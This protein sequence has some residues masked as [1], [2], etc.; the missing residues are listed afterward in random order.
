MNINKK[1]CGEILIIGEHNT[2]KSTLMNKLIEKKVSITS[3]KKNTTQKNILGIQTT[4]NYQFIYIDTPGF[5][6]NND[7]KKFLIKLNIEEKIKKKLK[8]IILVLDKIFWSNNIKIITNFFKKKK[9]NLIIALNK[10]DKIKKKEILLPFMKII[11]E[12]SYFKEIIPVSAKTGEN[13]HILK[14]EI[15]K[16]LPQKEHNF[17]KNTHENSSIE[18]KIYEIF[19]EKIMR[20][21]GDELPYTTNIKIYSIK[22]NK[23]GEIIIKSIIYIMHKRQKKIFIGKKGNK[24]KLLNILIKKDLEKIFKK[25]IHLYIWIKHKKNNLKKI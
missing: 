13:I 11:H 14:K 15:K 2:G 5:K 17:N 4:K 22:K 9:I 10:I 23:F 3:K 19:R 12:K 1:Y 16:Y 6:K 25:K 21:F 8:I 18:F 20:N 24:I 7:G